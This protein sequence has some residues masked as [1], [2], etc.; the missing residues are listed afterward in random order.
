L[1]GAEQQQFWMHYFREGMHNV[2]ACLDNPFE[3]GFRTSFW[4]RHTQQQ[5]LFQWLPETD[6]GKT[7]PIPS[8]NPQKSTYP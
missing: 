3:E 5:R 8:G 1:R 7:A 6:A 4:L 2:E